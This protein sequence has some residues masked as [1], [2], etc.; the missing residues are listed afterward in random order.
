MGRHQVMIKL[1]VSTL[2]GQKFVYTKP[3]QCHEKIK[4]KDYLKYNTNVGKD[5]S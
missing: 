3:Q 5:V 1:H 2:M 4:G